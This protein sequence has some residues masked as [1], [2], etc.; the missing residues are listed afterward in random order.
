MKK[1][2]K[3]LAIAL[4]IIF[5]IAL[6]AGGFIAYFLPN[7]GDAPLIK[8]D[9]TAERIERGK[10]L[11]NHVTVCIDCHSVS[12]WTK[13]SA[14][15]TGHPGAGGEK[16]SHD[17]GFPGTLYSPNITP[18]NLKGW[19]DGEIFRTITTGVGK[20]GNALFPVMPYHNYGLMDKEDI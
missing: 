12:D 2:F 15:P 5:L 16:F 14:P 9:Y 18:C 6:S 19:T 8:I 4:S 20:D 10:Y 1:I 11:A 3:V 13:F 17:M 7:V